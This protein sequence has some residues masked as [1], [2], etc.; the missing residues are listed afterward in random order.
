MEVMPGGFR[1]SK[2]PEH[3]G[4]CHPVILSLYLQHTSIP[5][6]PLSN[7]CMSNSWTA[8]GTHKRPKSQRPSKAQTRKVPCPE[9]NSKRT[10]NHNLLRG[11][12]SMHAFLL[13]HQSVCLSVCVSLQTLKLSSQVTSTGSQQLEV[14]SMA[15]LLHIC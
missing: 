3:P 12:V 4:I 8:L 1:C 11:D 2:W 15:L 10:S 13:S 14:S 6:I 7:L 5:I 9:R